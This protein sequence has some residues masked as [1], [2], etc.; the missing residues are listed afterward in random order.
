MTFRE[1]IRRGEAELA[2]AGID[3]PAFDAR[4]LCLHLCGW[5]LSAYA[6]RAGEETPPRL[7]DSYDALIKRRAAHEPLQYITGTA[8]F[9]GRDFFASPGVLI[10]RFDT[11]TVI[12]AVLPRLRPGMRIL[13]LCTG[14][15]CILLTLLLEGPGDLFGTGGDIS[16][17]AL[18]CARRNGARYAPELA[19]KGSS[20]EWIKSNLF[21]EISGQYDI[22]CANPPYIRSGDIPGLPREV[23]D[24]EPG[25]ALDGGTDG[26]DY[27]RTLAAGAP[28][29]LRSGGTAVF[30][31]GFDEAEETAELMRGAGFSD[32]EIR[33]DMGGRMRAVLGRIHA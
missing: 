12:D 15:G 14:S 18:S 1:M 24:Y 20:A 22:L 30:E 6:A 27:Y 5:N 31:T 7:P 11:E 10:P 13:D 26:M 8:P 9:F 16:E 25:L 17:D 29:F 3:N 28:A 32:I 33:K 19:R 2:A 4:E 23:R 21:A